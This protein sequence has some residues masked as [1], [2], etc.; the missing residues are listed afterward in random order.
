MKSTSKKTSGLLGGFDFKA[1]AK[2]IVEGDA[3]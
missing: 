1:L 3:E 2:M